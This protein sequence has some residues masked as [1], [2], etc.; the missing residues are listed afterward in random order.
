MD[1]ATLKERSVTESEAEAWA[2]ELDALAASKMSAAYNRWHTLDD[3]LD[4]GALLRG[5]HKI[6]ERGGSVTDEKRFCNSVCDRFGHE[7]M[8]GGTD[9]KALGKTFDKN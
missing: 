8:F 2:L 9:F 3:H 7:R 1:I 6:Q 4:Y 5:I